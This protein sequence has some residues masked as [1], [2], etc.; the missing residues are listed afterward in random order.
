[1]ST[2]RA[3]QNLA[4]ASPRRPL[5]RK[6]PCANAQTG[7]A[8][9]GAALRCS[10]HYRRED[11]RWHV[12]SGLGTGGTLSARVMPGNMIKSIGPVT[13]SGPACVE[14]AA[15]RS[16][17]VAERLSEPFVYVLDLLTEEP[18]LERV[19]LHL[20]GRALRD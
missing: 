7:C 13:L 15:V 6:S 4:S 19:F 5:E 10:G 14:S 12:D 3:N 2:R 20:T 18:N 16:L 1:M 17:R 11:E 9:T 8:R